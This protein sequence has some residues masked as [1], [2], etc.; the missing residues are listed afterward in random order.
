MRI[1]FYPPDIIRF[2]RHAGNFF[3]F[4]TNILSWT[5]LKKNWMDFVTNM[6]GSFPVRVDAKDLNG[7]SISQIIVIKI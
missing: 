6:D 2:Q 1:G 7:N 5:E 4:C 3:I